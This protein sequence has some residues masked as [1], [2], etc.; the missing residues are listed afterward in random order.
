MPP[1]EARD[2]GDAQGDQPVSAAWPTPTHAGNGKYPAG[3]WIVEASGLDVAL[4]LTAE[5]SKACNRKVEV[6]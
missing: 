2:P 3:F 6:W 5:G 4:K 1:A